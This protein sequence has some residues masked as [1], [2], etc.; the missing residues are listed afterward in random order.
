MGGVGG[1]VLAY[2][3]D[4]LKEQT[5]KDFE[6]VIT[7][8]SNQDELDVYNT[9]ELYKNDLNIKYIKT[10]AFKGNPAYNTNLGIES[11]SNEIVK[12]LCQDDYLLN[13]KSLQYIYEGFI[14]DVVWVATPYVHTNDRTNIYKLHIPTINDKLHYVNTIG[15]PSCIALKKSKFLGF[16]VNLKWAYDCEFYKR[17]VNCYGGPRV[18]SEVCMVNYIHANQVT[19]TLAENTL[20]DNENAYVIAKHGE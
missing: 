5:L 15:T 18:I 1:S 13:D 4:R 8:H 6:I 3:F 12:L 16:D 11:C 2:S 10:N 14:D 7:D 19:N 9:C 17:M 20:R